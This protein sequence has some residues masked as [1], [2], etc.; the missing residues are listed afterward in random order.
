[1]LSIKSIICIK[2]TVITFLIQLIGYFTFFNIHLD[3][4]DLKMMAD[5]VTPL[6]SSK[7]RMNNVQITNRQYFAMWHSISRTR[8]FYFSLGQILK[9][10]QT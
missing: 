5:L 9:Y 2:T 8:I 6:F 4:K 10:I 7:I 3:L 1:M